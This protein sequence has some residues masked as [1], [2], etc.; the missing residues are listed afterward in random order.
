MIGRKSALALTAAAMLPAAAI[1]HHGWGWAT[2]QQWRLTGS[3]VSV[4]FGNPHG[5]L[6]V[7]SNDV[8]WEVE[9]GQPWRNERAGLT[10]AILS[11]GTRV[12]I[13]GHRSKNLD[14]RLMKAERLRVGDRYYKLYPDRA[15]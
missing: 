14:E 5:T 4:E 11:P 1:A 13:H 3:V 8:N 10:E 6:I 9:I 2:D 12:R 7:E 15:S